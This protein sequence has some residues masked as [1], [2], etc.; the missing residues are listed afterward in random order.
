MNRVS[1]SA[2]IIATIIAMAGSASNN[3]NMTDEIAPVN[4]TNKFLNGLSNESLPAQISTSQSNESSIKM[5]IRMIVFNDTSEIQSLTIP[6]PEVYIK[7]T[8]PEMKRTCSSCQKRKS[9]N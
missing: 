9:N 3:F 4:Q 8:K 7:P 2:L 5:P 1:L 6:I